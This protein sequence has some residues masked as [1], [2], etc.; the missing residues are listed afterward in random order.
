MDPEFLRNLFIKWCFSAVGS[1]KC[2]SACICSYTGG[3]QS[4][5]EP[6]VRVV[7]VKLRR[8]LLTVRTCS[9]SA[10]VAWGWAVQYYHTKCLLFHH[11]ECPLCPHPLWST[12]GWCGS[13]LFDEVSEVSAV[14][15]T[16]FWGQI[17]V[18][19]AH[20]H[21]REKGARLVFFEVLVVCPL[22]FSFLPV[23]TR[24][25]VEGLTRST[26]LNLHWARWGKERKVQM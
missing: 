14:M 9:D 23:S 24:W 18:E 11:L 12:Q 13:W 8:L 5:Y 15:D 17:L 22:L 21:S 7:Q 3:C 1:C 19:S 6:P 4:V 2:A 16:H 26:L 20:I 25:F 10:R